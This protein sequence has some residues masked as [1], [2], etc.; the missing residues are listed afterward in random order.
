M[1]SA[2]CRPL[3]E[4][5]TNTKS[6]AYNKQ[7]NFEPLGNVIE[8]V[9]SRSSKKGIS[10]KYKLN[11]MG[12]RIQPCRTPFWSLKNSVLLAAHLIEHFVFE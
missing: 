4:C 3:A 5:E 12:E 7:F 11:N 8:S 2:F 6:S 10:F 9:S 1:E